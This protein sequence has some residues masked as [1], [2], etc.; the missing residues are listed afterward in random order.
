MIPNVEAQVSQNVSRETLERL[1]IYAQL[2]RTWN[3][4]INLVAPKTLD[5]LWSRHIWDS[6]QV[7]A[8]RPEDCSVWADLGSGGGF[9]GAVIAILGAEQPGLSVFLV[10]SDQRKATFLRTVARETGANFTVINKR[11]ED[12]EP[13]EADV[14]SARALAPLSDLLA[15]ASMHLKRDGTALLMKG[16]QHMSELE[17]ARKTWSFNCT[18]LPSATDKTAAILK[19]GGITRV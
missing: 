4:R 9:P 16:A 15:L 19:I 7:W 2:L 11:I 18:V 13:L 10:E 6:A 14:V 17:Q 3:P 1:E 12:V 5:D 8:H